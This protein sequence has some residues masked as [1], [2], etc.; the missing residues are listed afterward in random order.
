LNT[1]HRFYRGGERIL[2]FRGLP[3]PDDFDGHRPEDWLGSTTHLFAEGGDG[4]THLADGAD[5]PSPLANDPQGWLG[6]AHVARHGAEP[7]LLTRPLDGGERL[8]V[9]SH[10]DR[11]FAVRHL[12]CD[13]GKT[14]AWLILD[15]EPG[16]TVWVGFRDGL[17]VQELAALV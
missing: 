9:R 17:E 7:G 11:A 8:P 5:L 6:D 10:P 4:V 1:P 13:H 12:H 3:V 15:T 14:E 16:A 2:A